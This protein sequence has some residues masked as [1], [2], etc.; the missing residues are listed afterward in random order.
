MSGP[1]EKTPPAAGTE[2]A[3]AEPAPAVDVQA[4]IDTA[5]SQHTAKQTA[6][7]KAE[8]KEATGYETV[9]EL[10]EAQQIEQGNAKEALAEKSNQLAASEK[11]FQDVQIKNALLTASTQSID[12]DSVSAH[13]AH[14]ASCDE[15]G[16]VTIDG[17]PVAEA[18]AELL[19][20][21]PFLAKAEG[22]SGSGAPVAGQVKNSKTRAEFDALD[23][24]AKNKFIDDG[25]IV[26]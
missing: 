18:V 10:R 21:K 12:P 7:H 16:V 1:N 24:A 20:A 2:T 13:L 4:Q 23:A 25:G 17:K 26:V 19:K 8:L 3:N 22:D 9:A 15:N 14:K 5:I 6:Q 11:R